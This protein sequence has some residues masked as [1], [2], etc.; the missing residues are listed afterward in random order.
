LVVGVNKYL[1][2]PK[3]K[4]TDWTI[5]PFEIRFIGNFYALE[6]MI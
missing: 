5:Y 3:E 2:G 1:T 6:R 4:L